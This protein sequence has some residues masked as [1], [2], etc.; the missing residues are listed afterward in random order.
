MAQMTTDIGDGRREGKGAACTRSTRST[1]AELQ[2][3]VDIT[4]AAKTIDHR[5]LF[6]TVQ[7][8]EP[9]K[10]AVAGWRDGDAL[11]RVARDVVWNQQ[12]ATISEGTVSVA[13]EVRTWRDVPGVKA[14]A[15]IPQA[16]AAIDATEAD[17]RFR[18]ALAGR[19]ITDLT[20]LHVEPWSSAG[21]EPRRRRPPAGVA[22]LFT[23]PRRTTTPTRGRSAGCSRSSTST[24][25]EVVR[26]DDHGDVPGP[27]RGRRTTAHDSGGP[28][29]RRPAAAR[30]H[31]AGRAE[32]HGRRP[33][34]ALAEVAAADRLHAAR[35]ARAARRSPTTTT[36]ASGRSL[37]PRVD[38]RAGDPVRR[39][40]PDQLLQERVRHRRVRHRAAH[41]LARAG[42]RLPGRDPLPRRRRRRQHGRA[43]RRSRTRSACTRRTTACSGSTPTTGRATRGAPRR[44]ASWSRRS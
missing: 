19:G 38:R 18:E 35:G 3:V 40:Q 21:F 16:I 14:P 30:D 33:R 34:G 42:L 24:R 39:S 32:L 9:A 25:M 37:P 20:N 22:P 31:A 2:A 41:Q 44:G 13:G 36:T 8:D 11:D 15:L 43:V 12:T 17:P 27:G 29:P 10:A 7:L 28:L 26:V 23:A 1:P 4:R 5:H 6:V